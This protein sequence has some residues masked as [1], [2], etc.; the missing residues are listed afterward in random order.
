[1]ETQC[2]LDH[3][4]PLWVRIALAGVLLVAV[5]G[6]FGILVLESWLQDV[7]DDVTS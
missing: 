4:W 7:E 1:M 3:G 6:T 5:L 2:T